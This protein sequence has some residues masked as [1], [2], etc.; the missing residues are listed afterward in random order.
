[1]LSN[2]LSSAKIIDLGFGVGEFRFI[3][4]AG[5]LVFPVSYIFGD[6]LTEIYGYGRSRRV[7]WSG[8]AAT[9]ALAGFVWLAG[10]LPGE[11]TW[12][13][14]AG[15]S[16]YAAILGGVTGLVAAS[17][18]AYFAGEF[19]NSFVLA[20]MKVLTDGRWLW[21]RTIGSTLVGQGL[22]TLLFFFIAA[23]LG[24]FPW[25]LV[26]SLIVTN[27]VLKVGIEVLLTPITLRIILMLKR[28]EGEDV[29]DR[30]TDFNPFRIGR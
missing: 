14:Y 13:S 12:E 10:V 7:I 8:F 26:P 3:F 9:A 30:E 24:V 16:A 18:A 6:I 21:T 15:Q 22:D 4:D 29:F 2:L 28:V 19:A 25:E 23:A 1:M 17:L 5:T 20:R 27:Y 11:V